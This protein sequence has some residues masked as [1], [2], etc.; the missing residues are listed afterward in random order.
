M[1]RPHFS[2]SIRASLVTILLLAGFIL[3]SAATNPTTYAGD[4]AQTQEPPA[5][6]PG[7]GEVGYTLPILTQQLARQS[8]LVGIAKIRPSPITLAL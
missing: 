6:P 7:P 4:A 1:C 2:L 8:I 3:L 5:P